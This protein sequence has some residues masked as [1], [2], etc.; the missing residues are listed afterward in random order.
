MLSMSGLAIPNG[1]GA[2]FGG[3]RSLRKYEKD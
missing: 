1:A 2:V 3:E